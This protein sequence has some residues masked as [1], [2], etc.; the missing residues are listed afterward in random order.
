MKH[1]GKLPRA[2]VCEI[3]HVINNALGMIFMVCEGNDMAMRNAIIIRDYV[4]SLD[5]KEEF[6][7]NPFEGGDE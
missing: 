5:T 2:V 6:N 3:H 1:K 7:S 4:A